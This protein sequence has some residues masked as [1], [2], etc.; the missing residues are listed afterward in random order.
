MSKYE[1][2]TSTTTICVTCKY[3]DQ[4]VILTTYPPQ[5]YGKYFNQPVFIDSNKCLE[6]MKGGAG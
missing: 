4:S 2:I 3:L 1:P 5:A 6:D